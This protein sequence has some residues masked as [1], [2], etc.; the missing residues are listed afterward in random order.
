MLRGFKRIADRRRFQVAIERDPSWRADQG[1]ARFGGTCQGH[2]VGPVVAA[3]D[4]LSA[5]DLFAGLCRAA[6]RSGGINLRGAHTHT[7]AVG[8][9]AGIAVIARH[10]QLTLGHVNRYRAFLHA[11]VL[12]A[13][14]IGALFAGSEFSF[15]L[16]VSHTIGG[17]S[18]E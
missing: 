15:R 13:I 16:Q 18:V 12:H 8:H 11:Q 7:T 3:V 4:L 1:T 17:A 6:S 2:M 9:L 10:A 5:C 14:G